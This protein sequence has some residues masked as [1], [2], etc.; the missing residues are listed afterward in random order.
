MILC[1]K[2]ALAL[3][4]CLCLTGFAG[5]DA[6]YDNFGEGDAFVP[7]AGLGIGYVYGPFGFTMELERCIPI[8]VTATGTDHYLDYAAL[9][10]VRYKT[11]QDLE[12]SIR[13]DAGGVPGD[14][15]ESQ[16][17]LAAE[18]EATVYTV[19]FSG[20]S[21]LEE[22]KTY[23]AHLS[24]VD[25]DSRFNWLETAN[26]ITGTV[27][28]RIQKDH[29]WSTDVQEYAALRL[30]TTPLDPAGD[31]LKDLSEGGDLHVFGREYQDKVSAGEGVFT[32]DV[33]GDNV[34]D[35][36]LTS[37]YGAGPDNVREGAG[38]V[39]VY[40][41]ST[42]L[43]G[44]RDI[45]GEEGPEPDLTIFGASAN[46][47]L[48]MGR[49]VAVGDVNGDHIQDLVLGAWQADGPLGNRC[50]GG[51][52]Y[53][54]FGSSALSGTLDL[55]DGGA[56]LIVYGAGCG[57]NLGRD[58]AIRLGDLNNDRIADLILA[59]PGADGPSGARDD[60][61][62]IYFIQ[63][64]AALSGTV[65]LAQGRWAGI[66]YGASMNDQLGADGSLVLGDW[67][68]DGILDLAAGSPYADGPSDSRSGCGEAYIL[69][70]ADQAF[71]SF[72]LKFTAPALRV[73]GGDYG[74]ALTRYQ[75]LASGDV[76]GDGVDDLVLGAPYADGTY[77]NRSNCGEVHV[78]YG[79]DGLSGN[80]D[81]DLNES[82]VSILGADR[83]D[84]LGKYQGLAVG[85]LNGDGLDDIAMASTYAGGPN[86]SRRSCGEAAVVFGSASLP[87]LVDLDVEEQDLLVYGAT[88][89]DRL[90]NDGGLLAADLNGD[91]VKD[92]VLASAL[93]DG[94]GESRSNCGE[95]Y[96]IHG[97]AALSGT[98][99]I[100]SG[101]QDVLIYGPGYNDRMT[102]GGALTAGD[103]NA[104]GVPDA[105][106]GAFRADGPDNARTCSG[107]V[108]GISGGRP[109]A[110]AQTRQTDHAGDPL[111][112]D[113][114]TARVIIDYGTGD[115]A[116]MTRATLIRSKNNVDLG[117]ETKTANVQWILETDRENFAAT[118]VFHYLD[119]EVQGLDESKLQVFAA[120]E[121]GGE[122][123]PLES[124][125]D[126]AKNLLTVQGVAEFG[127]FAI[128]EGEPAADDEECF[129]KALR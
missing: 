41:G 43:G 8:T 42:G 92:L 74:D 7:D 119:A 40:F 67:N 128:A 114:G 66:V 77:N 81:L 85:D 69:A 47:A 17:F 122:Y 82:D 86:N 73:Y 84:Y 30:T 83:G 6:I 123:T 97:G 27:A 99:D 93:A 125:L 56:D 31:A 21:I 91:G 117:E 46:D 58:G 111:P 60:C 87:A 126:Q 106:L 16:Y 54:I 26:V 1:K 52:V 78:I 5:A 96:I 11:I 20:V 33:N 94:P 72:D 38:E 49:A 59:A 22:G 121:Q 102:D 105:V 68:G 118:L 108:F 23:W 9:P 76:N 12:L 37:C 53:V 39:Y 64:G 113:Y 48:G 104:N 98:L 35:L 110:S 71:P 36:I 63:G 34:P 32:G 55:D 107:E 19:P 115:A 65:D 2:G 24:Y 88:Y 101:G 109:P 3:L 62:E 51:E 29:A 75:A 18:S 129:I 13:E 100:F 70:G 127:S 15:V 50:S 90:G 28:S 4:F 95:A 44:I 10:V 61:G 120:P 45:L 103:F 80:R 116:S 89:G 57:D 25:P 124:V 14:L 79:A 112:E